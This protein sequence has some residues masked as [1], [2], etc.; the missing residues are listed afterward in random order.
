LAAAVFLLHPAQTESVTWVSQRSGLLSMLFMLAAWHGFLRRKRGGAWSLAGPAL[1][2]AALLSKEEA[3]VL[4]LLLV[5]QDWILAPKPELDK[6]G[7]PL[8]AP[9]LRSSTYVPYFAAVIGLILAKRLVVGQVAQTEY[10]GGGLFYTVLTTV[11][12]WLIFLKLLFVP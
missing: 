3:V 8:P 4:P 6:K 7:D 5:A 2:V 9:R 11:K 1:F 12:G 10:W